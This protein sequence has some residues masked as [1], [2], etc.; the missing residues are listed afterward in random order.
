MHDIYC[1]EGHPKVSYDTYRKIFKTTG[2]KFH[3]P[4][5][6]GCNK[7]DKLDIQI[8]ST[9]GDEKERFKNLKELHLRKAE[10]GYN[11]KRQAKAEA[12]QDPNSRVLIFDLQQCLPTPHLK[13][14]DIFYAR[15]LYVYN[16][17]VTDTTTDLTHCYMWSEV[18]GHRGANEIASCLLQHIQ[19]EIPVGVVKLKLF[20]D[21]CGGQNR[22]SIII[23]AMFAALQEHPSLEQVDH[24]FL[25]PGHTFLPEVDSRHSV[26]EK[27]K[28]KVNRINVPAEWYEGV[29]KAGMT[30]RKKFPNGKFQVVHITKFYD[31]M[32]LAKKFFVKRN[33]CL[34]KEPF[35]YL[36]THWMKFQKANLG[37]VDVKEALNPEA[38]FKTLSFLRRGM[39]SDRLPRILQQIPTP[40]NMVVPMSQEKKQNLLDLLKFLEPKFHQYYQELTVK[41]VP[42]PE[43]HPA[44]PAPLNE[45]EDDEIDE[46]GDED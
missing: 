18:E 41:L 10:M 31:I 8:T 39:R 21:C 4:K 37:L 33:K 1:E 25:V 13:C 36:E 12:E 3:A 29:T 30:D 40:T 24:I 11:L 15:Q 2:R 23:T 5:T 26:I 35:K 34:K 6:D 16:F 45:D 46:D 14:K 17:T 27:Y 20:S 42:G 38:P 28:K 7:C 43:H 32:T 19:Q 9:E 22:N 44:F